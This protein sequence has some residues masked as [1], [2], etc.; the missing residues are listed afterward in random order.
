M[1]I[2][3]YNNILDNSVH[4]IINYI[5]YINIILGGLCHNMDYQ[6][7]LTIINQISAFHVAKAPVL[8]RIQELLK[9]LGNPQKQL[10]CIHVAGTNGKGS[11]CAMLQS[12]LTQSGYKTALYT[13][14]HLIKY[15][16][17]FQIDG[18]CISDESF[19]QQVDIVYQHY[20]QMID[21]G[22]DAPTLFE[23]LTAICF[24]YF[25]Q[26]SVDILILEVGLG[27][28]CDATN[29]IENPLICMIMSIG[30][31]HME[32]LGNT[33]Q[34]ITLEKAGIIK[35][36]CSVVLYPQKNLVYNSIVDIC[37]Q[38][39]CCIY[40]LQQI[41][42]KILLQNLE[43]TLFSVTTKYFQYNM[44]DL[45]LL[46]EYQI[47]NCI[48]VLLACHV[49]NKKGFHLTEQSILKGISYTVWHGRMEMIQKKPIVIL[50]GAH[51]IDGISM[52]SRSIKKYFKHKKITL[53]LGVLNDKEY[54]KMAQVILPIVDT[55]VLTEPMSHRKL[56]IDELEK[57][58][59]H[60]DKKILKNA[61]VIEA[62]KT[63][64]HLTSN[65]DVLICCGSLYMI[66]ELK[67]N[68]SRLEVLS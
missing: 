4:T 18:V 28:T 55:V 32:Y 10:K 1:P 61:H 19:A 12:I 45:R 34:K 23:F 46:G 5:S 68:I 35:E 29:I 31:D 38:K 67:N 20:T 44:V 43:K 39:Q 22:F 27:G 59:Q 51:N 60:F 66:G 57:T 8:E 53:L 64:L 65:R 11:A 42:T 49:L 58:V 16:E 30:M 6:Q 25:A 56:S 50:D 9:R 26:Q 3:A 33:L 21:A 37:K 24:H 47:Q 40:D 52:L 54:Q 48:T 7:A 41:K 15:N 2:T 17:R 14:P 36:N 13:S 62:Y 63:A